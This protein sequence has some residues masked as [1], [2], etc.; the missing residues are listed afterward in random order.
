[1]RYK[2]NLDE[3]IARG[4][5]FWTREDPRMI[6]AKIDVGEGRTMRMWER[7]LEP[8]TCP[9]FRR[10]FEVFRQDF[11]G[12]AD[13]LDDA[14]PAA[15]PNFGDYGFGAYAGADVVFGQGGAYARP[16]ISDLGRVKDLRVDPGNQWVRLLEEATG[17]FADQ[18][19]GLC[20]TSIIETCD[21]LNFAENAFGSSIFL[22]IHDHPRELL[23]LFDFAFDLNVSL[24]EM[25][26]RHIRRHAGGYVDLHEEWLPGD[27]VWLSID[28]WGGCAPDAFRRLGR[29]HVQ[30][31][32]DRFGAGWLH[33]H[34]AHLHLLE[35]VS[36]LKGLIGIGILDDPNAERCFGQLERIRRATGGVPLQVNCRKNE[37]L[38]AL[39]D[40]TLP[41][42]VMYWIDSGVQ[43]VEEANR[44][45]DRVR[46]Y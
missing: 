38:A 8:G 32:I 20:A 11:E 35:E 27:C 5:R 17:Y 36:T 4:R 24:I 9:D 16:F 10:M 28:A 25:Q 7:A 37:F 2:K 18:S 6:L 15:R 26:R 22:E 40:E 44:I 33:M 30:R 1:M 39:D 34:S 19:E 31:M 42:G 13:L 46:A 43:S 3:V 29:G 14:V 41:R 45:M 12:R 23:D 21:S